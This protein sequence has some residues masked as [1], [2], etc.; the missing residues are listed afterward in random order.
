M[1]TK[2]HKEMKMRG[3]REV[4]YLG[5]TVDEMIWEFMEEQE[6]P[7]LTLAIVQAPYIPRVVGYGFSDAKQKRL[8]SVNTLWPAGLI[9]QGYAAV[10]AMQLYEAG[11]L[12]LDAFASSYADNI[13]D[14]WKRITP[15][16]LIHHA[17]GLPDY[18]KQD[19]FSLARDWSF[20]ELLELVRDLPLRFEPGTQVEQSATNFLLLTEIIERV[21]GVSYQDFVKKNQ[22]ELLG[23]KHTSFSDGLE[24]YLQEDLSLSNYVHQIFKTDGH[25]IDPAETA[26]SY[27]E[28][29][30]AYPVMHS[31]A[32][33]GFG[34]V[35]ASAQDISFWDIG[36]AG[37]VLIHKP[38]NRAVVY[39]PW[40]LPDGSV[41]PASAGWQFYHHRG[42][43]DIKGSLPG[44]SSFLSRFTHPEELVCVTL[45]ANKEGV[46]FTN[47]GRMI[48]GA[49]GDLLS[50]NYD[51]NRL[52]LT[53]SQF[54]AD[55]TVERLENK[56]KSMGIPV[57]A[58]FDHA[59]NAA[60]VGLALRLTTVLVFGAAKVGTGLMQ[61]DQSIALELPLKIAV[62]EDEAGSTWIG[63][64]KMKPVA[65]EY[66]LSERPVIDSMQ[67]LLEKL[68]A[69]AANIYTNE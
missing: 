66:G 49:F 43:M 7:G 41:V 40:R 12:D 56:L 34:D 68:S 32:L 11:E 30:S 44:Y 25:Y 38:E 15:R 54:S 22:L 52:F 6:I 26:V 55:E 50:T 65:E 37:G 35:Y 45:M 3:S 13:P 20:K 36:L 1:N 23:L 14:S 9:S 21:S 58:K 51:D 53:E 59:K 67:R 5:R 19:G 18:R 60:E 2:E 8:A 31:S 24:G 29:G 62:W 47:L 28:D 39:A 33:R 16:Q 17:A 27:Q 4:S 63:F 48:A 64:K 42:L 46:D 61:A 69:A 57:F 10:A